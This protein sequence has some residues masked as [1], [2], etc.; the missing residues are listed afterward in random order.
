MA[1]V[2]SSD[3]NEYSWCHVAGLAKQG[4]QSITGAADPG[5]RVIRATQM[6]VHPGGESTNEKRADL[7]VRYLDVGV[8]SST[9]AVT[10]SCGGW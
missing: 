7:R 3:G 9:G 8:T 5:G 10:T 6:D 2:G 1:M 4:G